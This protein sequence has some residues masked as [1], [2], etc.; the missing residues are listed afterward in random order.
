MD[1]KCH[2]HVIFPHKCQSGIGNLSKQNKDSAHCRLYPSYKN[3]TLLPN[4]STLLTYLWCPD[5]GH[6][7]YASSLV[8]LVLA[9]GNAG[10]DPL[11]DVLVPPPAVLESLKRV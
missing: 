4:Q 6:V 8:P 3:K 10:T 1:V 2:N 9:E 7:S 11:A 5:E